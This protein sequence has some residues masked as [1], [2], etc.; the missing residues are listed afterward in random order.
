MRRAVCSACPSPKMSNFQLLCEIQPQITD[1]YYSNYWQ[2][3]DQGIKLQCEQLSMLIRFRVMNCTAYTIQYCIITANKSYVTNHSNL[4]LTATEYEISLYCIG[5]AEKKTKKFTTS[6][7]FKHT[8][9]LW[10][11]LHDH[12]P[13]QLNT[14]CR[15]SSFYKQ[16]Q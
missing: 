11:L 7:S 15:L 4:C 16:H 8:E 12:P 3:G 14:K 13:G 1:S 10:M 5:Y 9:W 2:T 6:Q